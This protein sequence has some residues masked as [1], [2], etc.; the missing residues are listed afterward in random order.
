MQHASIVSK[1]LSLQTSDTILTKFEGKQLPVSTLV[2]LATLGGAQVCNF[3]NYIGSFQPGKC[4]DALLITM[5]PPL[6][7]HAKG[8]TPLQRFADSLERFIF[9]GDERNISTV[10]VKGKS[11]GG[12]RYRSSTK[13]KE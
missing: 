3:D 6:G 11:I 2:F 1:I 12:T 8:S 9:T 7:G 13:L 5:S 10:W 4:F